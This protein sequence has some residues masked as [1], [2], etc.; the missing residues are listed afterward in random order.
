MFDWL[1]YND[2]FILE[3]DN[4]L[5]LFVSYTKYF[6]GEECFRT[7]VADYQT[8]QGIKSLDEISIEEGDWGTLYQSAPCLPLKPTYRAI[9]GHIA[10]GRIAYDGEGKLY[11]G[12]GDY[13]W[14]G[15]FAEKAIAQLDGYEY[16]KVIEIDIATGT[17]RVISKGH[18]NPQGIAFDRSGNLYVVEHGMRG[19]DELNHVI[20]GRDYGFPSETL[21]TR[22]SKLPLPGTFAQGRHDVFEPPV[23]AWL[24]SVAISSLNR[25][26]GFHD[27]WD[28]DLLMATLKDR[29]LYRI[30]MTDEGIQFAER[31]EIGERIRYAIQLGDHLVLW[32]D[33]SSL[34]FLA[35][36]D[37]AFAQDFFVEYF[38]D[39]DAD[40]QVSARIQSALAQCR[41]CHSLDLGDDQ[42]APSLGQVFGAEIASTG[43]GGYS[44]ALRDHTGHWTRKTLSSFIAHPDDVAEGTTMPASGVTDPEIVAGVVDFL[45]ALASH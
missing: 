27:T 5:R 11:L 33:S 10:G 20:E 42:T 23:F 29:S 13:H 40:A 30:R 34:I 31:I 17:S 6:V 35:V 43:F 3:T 38:E 21:G 41:E 28:G 15:M 26:D 18:R 2:I 4:A 25:I 36:S 39:L 19:G 22:Y 7:V 45:E 44:D 37:A 24:P 32:T 9:E 14:D 8:P 1:R 16:G 12:V